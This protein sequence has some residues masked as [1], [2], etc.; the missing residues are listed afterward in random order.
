MI[1]C[2]EAVRRLW[3]YVEHELDPGDRERIDDHLA[4]CR[5]CC[6]EVEFAEELRR[7]MARPPVASLPPEVEARFDAFLADLEA[8]GAP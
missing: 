7:F 5:R 4:F 8:E 3:E 6:G 2:S 1:S